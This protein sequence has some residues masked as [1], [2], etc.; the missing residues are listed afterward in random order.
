MRFNDAVSG[1]VFILLAIGLIATATTFPALPGQPYGA[2][3]FPTVIGAGFAIC[4]VFLVVRGLSAVGRRQP[5]LELDPLL[6]TP[7]NAISISLIV[8][9]TLLYILLAD[10]IGF[11]PVAF[12]LL[13]GLF[14]WFRVRPLNA[15]VIAALFTA[16]TFWFFANML[17]VPLPRGWL[18]G[19]I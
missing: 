16:A 19:I 10:R 18:T 1:A 15:L 4:G 7:R 2:A 5:P 9:A 6:R 11:I 14:L 12:V 17:R 3:L 13:M 8:A